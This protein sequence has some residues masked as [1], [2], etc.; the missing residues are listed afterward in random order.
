M[1]VVFIGVILFP[2]RNKARAAAVDAER[3][4]RMQPGSEVMTTSGLYGTVVSVN[5]EGTAVVSIAQGVEVKWALAALREVA[6]LP[7]QYRGVAPTDSDGGER[8]VAPDESG[9]KHS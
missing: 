2:R 9:Q 3:R 5:P 4:E 1:A 8:A 7:D 6:E